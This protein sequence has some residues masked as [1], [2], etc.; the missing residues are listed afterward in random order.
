[1]PISTVHW[2][3]WLGL[4]GIVIYEHLGNAILVPTCLEITHDFWPFLQQ[5]S[6]YHRAAT[7]VQAPER[8][9]SHVIDAGG[10]SPYESGLY[11]TIQLPNPLFIP[12]GAGE[13]ANNYICCSP[14]LYHLF[15]FSV[16]FMTC[17]LSSY[18]W[19]ENRTG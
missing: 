5:F 6:Y 17:F 1:M 10:K 15:C 3:R 14:I 16:I 19:T 12:L 13:R 2:P 4:K 18:K 9:S 11:S 8:K 7:C